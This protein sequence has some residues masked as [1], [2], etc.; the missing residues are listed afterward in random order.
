M[1]NVGSDPSTCT[2][3][4][5]EGAALPAELLVGA[6]WAGPLYHTSA[7]QGARGRGLGAWVG[8]WVGDW[9]RGI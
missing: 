6:A 3:E 1:P 2:T 7:A 9:V 5:S 4:R 8:G